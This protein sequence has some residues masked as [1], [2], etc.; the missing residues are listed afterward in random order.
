MSSSEQ[1]ATPAP[2]SPGEG[3]N[4]GLSAVYSPSWFARRAAY[5]PVYRR[6]AQAVEELWH[7]RSILD[8]GCGAGYLL[9]HFAGKAPICGVDGSQAALDAAPSRVRPFCSLRDLAEEPFLPMKAAR[10]AVAVSIEVA[11]HIPAEHVEAFLRWFDGADRVLLTA[12]PPGQGGN[13]HVNEQPQ[14]YWIERFEARSLRYDPPDTQAWQALARRYTSACPWVPRNAMV[15]VRAALP[16]ASRNSPSDS[17]VG[18]DLEAEWLTATA[19]P[20]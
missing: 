7:P 4:N 18:S 8:V 13:H 14:S 16:S 3:G 17:A 5:R 2:H 9:E 19:A 10:W 20:R 1:R 12:A 15:F 11:E 6:F